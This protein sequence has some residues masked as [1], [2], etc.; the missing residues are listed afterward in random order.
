MARRNNA[1]KSFLFKMKMIQAMY[2]DI[3]MP[4]FRFEGSYV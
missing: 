1:G 4:F 3:K 2:K